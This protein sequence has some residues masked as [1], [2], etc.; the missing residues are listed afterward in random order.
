MLKCPIKNDFSFTL[1]DL[2]GHILL[3]QCHPVEIYIHTHTH[4]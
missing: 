3:T 4:I 2:V 1:Q